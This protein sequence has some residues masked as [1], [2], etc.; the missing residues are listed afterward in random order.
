MSMIGYARVSTAEQ[1]TEAT[2]IERLRAE[3]CAVIREEKASGASRD[4]RTELESTL[5]LD[6]GVA[7]H[8]GVRFQLLEQP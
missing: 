5:T 2:Q 1:D 6:Q 4:G 8:L 7:E 3:G